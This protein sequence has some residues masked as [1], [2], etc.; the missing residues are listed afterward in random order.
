[1]G[2]LDEDIVL[3]TA[4]VDMYS[5]CGAIGKA[6][7]AL[8][9]LPH[10][11]IV[12]WN[13]LIAAYSQ[14]GRC[15]EA[16]S[17]YERIRHEGLFPDMA[18]YVSVLGACVGAAG[19]GAGAGAGKGKRI[20]SEIVNRGFEK[21]LALGNALV[22]MYAKC[23][24]LENAREVLDRLVIRDIASWNTLIAAYA[25]Q[26]QWDQ[27]LKCYE[28]MQSEG[29]FPDAI[30]YICLLKTCGNAG[31]VDECERVHEEITKTGL[32]G[33][34]IVLGNALVDM[35]A[36]CGML[37]KAQS[38][39][40]CLPLRDTV[41]WNAL[42]AGY[43][44][45]GR[46]QEAI[47]CFVRMRTDGISPDEVTFLCVLSACS[48]SGLVDFAQ[49][50]Y[51]SMVEEYGIAP[52]LGHCMCMVVVFGSA[53]EFGKAAS[54]IRSMPSIDRPALWLA[55]LNACRKWGNAKL[56]N[57][58]FDHALQL[59]PAAGLREDADKIEQKLL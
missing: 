6:H 41:S 13:A 35:Y 10:R 47:D 21:E 11:D 52:G 49:V 12:S 44:E 19:A 29:L 42:I 34:D 23:G 16:W 54:A 39:L 3:G 22:D 32:I 18:T 50:L 26:G 58:A 28:H 9:E 27:A 46:G 2:Y 1:V 8:E 57:L 36:K 15:T 5:K 55:L 30:T 20:H 25:Q 7:K 43:A 45:E 48:H 4:L 33:K 51:T 14:Q 31:A 38:V 59:F 17:C 37:A 53:G 56:A 24:N 40:E